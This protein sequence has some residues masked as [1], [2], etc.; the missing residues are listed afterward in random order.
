MDGSDK[1][2]FETAESGN[3]LRKLAAILQQNSTVDDFEERTEANYRL[4]MLIVRHITLGYIS[5]FEMLKT[6]LA[7]TENASNS[8]WVGGLVA[9]LNF[10]RNV[11][12]HQDLLMQTGWITPLEMLPPE[13]HEMQ[14]LP[15]RYNNLIRHTAKK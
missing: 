12:K 11:R 7:Q 2:Y 6:K 4:F 15:Q 1:T 5:Q 14:M 9:E 3:G 13:T 10:L 8:L